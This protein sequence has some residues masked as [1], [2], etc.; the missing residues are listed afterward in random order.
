MFWISLKYS[1]TTG[2]QW[3]DGENFDWSTIEQNAVTPIEI[4]DTC[5]AVDVS[6]DYSFTA[7]ECDTS[8]QKYYPLCEKV[9]GELYKVNN[10]NNNNNNIYLKSNVHKS[11]INYKYIYTY[12]IK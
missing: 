7:Q 10:I 2:W 8:L 6:N 3:L 9:V 5:I 1:S 12:K 4:N 11:S